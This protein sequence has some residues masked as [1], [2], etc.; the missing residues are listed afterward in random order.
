MY[1]RV[2]ETVGRITEECSEPTP[3]AMPA[4]GGNPMTAQMA[5]ATD[6][7]MII[8]LTPG[9]QPESGAQAWERWKSCSSE[10]LL[11]LREKLA[12]ARLQQEVARSESEGTMC[13]KLM[14]ELKEERCL[15]LETEKRL[16]EVTLESEISTS[17]MQALQEQFTRMEETVRNLL[18]NQGALGQSAGA[19]AD[20]IKACQGKLSEEVAVCKKT[21]ADI[22]TTADERSESSIEEKEK[23]MHL[24][25]RL[26]ALEAENSALA[27]ENEHQREQYECCLDEVANQVVQALLTQK[28][29]REECLK[30]RTRVFD[31]EQQNR[32]LS[33]LFQQRV[34]L[35]SD[36]LL[37]KLHSRIVDLSSGDLFSNAERNRSPIQSRTTETQIQEAQQN[38]QSNVPVLKCQSQLNLT[39]P[40]QLYPRSSCSSS[41][42]SLSSACSEHSSGSFTWNEG[43]TC[44][45]RSSLS[46][47][48]RLSIGSSLPSNLSSPAEELPPTRKKESHIL[49]GLKKLQKRKPLLDPPS[50]VSKWAY[51]DCM[52]SNEGIYSLGLKCRNHKSKDQI[53]FKATNKGMCL[54]QSKT[55]GYDSDSLD[56]AD[57][58]CTIIIPAVNEVP[59]KDSKSFCKK[60]THSVSDSLFGWDHNVKCVSEK[61]THLSSREKP[62]KLTSFVSSFQSSEKLCTSNKSPTN[63]LQFNSTKLHYKDLTIQLSDTEDVEILDELHLECTEEKNSSD[64]VTSLLTDKR[65]VSHAN[66]LSCKKAF[67]SSA[68]KDEGHFSPCS[69][70]RPKTLNLLKENCQATKVVK[71]SSEECITI[72]FDAEDGQPI[73]FNSQQTAS[74]TVSS[75][76]ISSPIALDGNHQQTVFSIEDAE[77]VPQ[78]LIGCQRGS[79]ARDYTVLKSLESHTEQK[80][81]EDP[82][83]NKKTFS[84][85]VRR[86]S[87]NSERPLTPHIPQQQKL[88]K[89]VFN[90]AYKSNCVSSLQTYSTQKPHLTKIPNRGKSSPQKTSKV[91]GSDVSNTFST[92]GSLIQD[93]PPVKVSKYLKMP[94]TSINHGLKNGSTIP[95]C[96]PQLPR[97]SKITFHNETGKSHASIAQGSFLS[98]RQMTD[99]GERPTRD[100]HDHL[101]LEEIKSPSPPPPPGRSTSLLHRPNYEHS[102]NIVAKTETHIP[103]VTNKDAPTCSSLKPQG[104]TRSV[105][106]CVQLTK[107]VQNQQSQKS[108]AVAELELSSSHHDKTLFQSSVH[109]V[110]QSQ[111]SNG[112]SKDL[113]K[114]SF[115]KKYLKTNCSNTSLS[116]HIQPC[117]QTAVK[118]IRSLTCIH[119]NQKDP[120]PQNTFFAKTG[121]L[122]ENGLMLQCKPSNI[123]STSSQCHAT[124]INEPSSQPQPS[125]LSPSSSSE[126]H[127]TFYCSDEKNLKTR[128]PVGQKGF[129]KSPPLLRKSST[130]PGKHEKDSINIYSKGNVIQEK[131]RKADASENTKP[132]EQPDSVVD[133]EKKGDIRDGVSGK[134]GFPAEVEDEMKHFRNTADGNDVDSME[135]KAFKRSISA[136]N[137]PYLKPALGMNGAKARSQSFSNQTGEKPS[138]SVVDGP[139]KVRTQIITNTTERGNS[140]TRQNSTGAEGMQTKPA[141]GSSATQSPSHSPRTVDFSYSRQV[142]YGS[143][144]SSSSHHSSPS[145][146]PCRTPPKGEGHRSSLKC[147][148]NQSPPQKETRSLP[149]SDRSSEKKS[150]QMPQKGK[151]IILT[152]YESQSSPNMS[153]MESLSKLQS[154]SKLNMAKIVKKQENL[155]N[156][157]EISDKVLIPPSVSVTQCTIE[158][159]VMLGIQENMQK[160]QGQDKTQVSEI[161]QK[162]GPSIANWFG[163]RKSKLPALSSKKSDASKSKDEKKE[164]KSGSG[165]GIKQTK[166]DKKK[167]KRKNEKDC[168][169]EN[170]VTKEAVNCDKKLGSVFPSKS[171]E[172]TRHETHYSRKTSLA[173]KHQ[174][175]KDHDVPIKDST[176]DQFMQELLHRVDKKAAHQKEN[177]SNHVSCRNMSKGNS[178]GS[179]FPS[180]SISVQANHGKNYKM[181]PATEIQNEIHILSA[182]EK[183]N[184]NPDNVKEA[185]TES[186]CQDQIIGSSC[187]MRT[188]DSGI[189]TFPLPDSTNRATGRHVPKTTS[190]LECEL[191][192][193][194]EESPHLTNVSQK[195]K[196][197]EREVPCSVECSSSGQDMI[198]HSA[199]DPTMAAKAKQAFQSCLPKPSTAGLLKPKCKIQDSTDQSCAPAQF[200][201][202]CKSDHSD[203]PERMKNL[204]QPTSPRVL[205]AQERAMR[206]CSYSASS[207]D[208]ETEAEFGTNEHGTGGKELF[209]KMKNNK[210]GNQQQH[211][212]KHPCFG[213]QSTVISFYQPNLYML[214]GK[215]MPHFTVKQLHGDLSKDGK[216]GDIPSKIKQGKKEESDSKLSNLPAIS[217]DTLNRINS[218]S[219]RIIEEDK[220]CSTKPEAE[221]ETVGKNEEPSLSSPEKAG[222]DNLES[223][224]DSLYDSF[225]SCASQASNEV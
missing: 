108:P 58:D 140:L 77:L 225:S 56:D 74:V 52:N 19:T 207:S 193:S 27:L 192:S 69:D 93:K 197:L 38:T 94:S 174:G 125:C 135:I 25:E 48:K 97:N 43:K 96:S 36:S 167:D 157:P 1:T 204:Q 223:L 146:L 203:L 190:C 163:F 65:S 92:S 75:N 85:I 114:G 71:T 13:E 159:K 44:S 162:T 115:E 104:I 101:E 176:N 82:E 127:T 30:L 139:G 16:R 151:N 72:V 148:G 150:K 2:A 121:Q 158:A 136:N 90:G 12:V 126:G 149:L 217:L 8:L 137:K 39:V 76:E 155:S 6:Q 142:S 221:K 21:A 129:L 67:F 173:P 61:L 70:N 95:K 26:R 42:L 63:K 64:F 10:D 87:V 120:S 206:L 119:A 9:N 102:L 11:P 144:S 116:A 98:R 179:A 208:N 172:I 224:S 169:E 47:E 216:V 199:S 187:Q 186:T 112:V 100:K 209:N 66:L 80:T 3:S 33:V 180:N 154:P 51:K 122:H 41:E 59:S 17:Q 215:E 218:N 202:T 152:G 105:S 185:I 53:P 89:P 170:D 211:I 214:Y 68:D 20:L 166:L 84:P 34:R 143:I 60:L 49:E 62:E 141:G 130:V 181:K 118:M 222:V 73:K 132:L 83:V 196:T 212:D 54:E 28:D 50:I 153:S 123:L 29:L 22:N 15:R 128:I 145:K 219:L 18:Q 191:S 23:T 200:S 124:S 110:Q 78:E 4:E 138:V 201:S 14:H 106:S 7:I 131:S 134:I 117:P 40:S 37:Q 57:D 175:Y 177:G 195:A 111:D 147:D 5:L 188:L 103:V 46:W 210:H 107:E 32:T 31:L 113:T 165:S 45:K 99:R 171:C 133:F 55:F 184:V 189:G 35:A 91:K 198:S 205:S 178:H 213:N 88:L 109:S 81:L 160:V 164:I 156:S 183:K 194:L 24:L 161:K 168:E 79:D 86:D 182:T 220:N